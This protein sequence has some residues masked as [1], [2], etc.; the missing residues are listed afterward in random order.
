MMAVKLEKRERN[1]RRKL[2]GWNDQREW[3]LHVTGES[4]GARIGNG[5]GHQRRR[6]FHE[7]DGNDKHYERYFRHDRA[8]GHAN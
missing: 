3:R 7:R 5:A 1:S 2:D 6:R 4:A 8:P